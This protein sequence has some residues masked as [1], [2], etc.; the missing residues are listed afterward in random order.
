MSIDSDKCVGCGDR[1][2]SCAYG[3]L[4]IID[5]MIILWNQKV[6]DAKDCSEECEVKT[7]RIVY[8]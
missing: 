7:M 6:R 8:I 4:E 2:R 1:M 3:V 5:N